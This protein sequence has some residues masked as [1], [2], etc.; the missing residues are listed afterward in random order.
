MGETGRRMGSPTIFGVKLAVLPCVVGMSLD[1]QL[2]LVDVDWTP[3]R[4]RTHRERHTGRTKRRVHER[5]AA[6]C[7]SVRD[8]NGSVGR[9][10]NR[11]YG[12]TDFDASRGLRVASVPVTH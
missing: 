11:L 4:Q 9:G 12:S 7:I 3:E 1:R 5:L 8:G 10:L 2:R 6:A